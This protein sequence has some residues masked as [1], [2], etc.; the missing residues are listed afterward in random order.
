MEDIMRRFC[1]FVLIIFF[2]LTAPGLAQI[3]KTLSYQ[4]VLTNDSG[5]PL[6]GDRALTFKLYDAA[7]GGS[8]LWLLEEGFRL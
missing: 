3:P 5:E 4:G 1:L 2:S 6:T 7:S 8:E